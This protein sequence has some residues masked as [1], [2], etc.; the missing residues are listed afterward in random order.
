MSIEQVA[1]YTAGPAIAGIVGWVTARSTARGTDA[2]VGREL[3]NEL[4]E[5]NKKLR[6][7]LDAAL[8]R[9]DGALTRIDKLER[10]VAAVTHDNVTLREQ[11]ELERAA[12][13]TAEAKLA[14]YERTDTQ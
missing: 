9:L 4:R 14:A 5:D 7:D 13:R 8:E 11:L 6:T 2:Q 3:R 1:S 12:R 10:H